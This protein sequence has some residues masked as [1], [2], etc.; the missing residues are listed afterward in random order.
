MTSLAHDTTNDTRLPDFMGTVRELGR[1]SAE[2]KDALPNLAMAFARAVYDGVIDIAKDKD[3][4]DGAARVFAA[5]SQAEGKKA[6]HDRTEKGLKANV[7]KLRQIGAAA[8]NPKFDFVDVLNRAHTIRQEAKADDIDVKPAYA[9][10]VDVA[11]EQLKQDDELTDEQIFSVVTVTESTKDVTLEGK[12]KQVGKLLEG[13]ITGEK[14]KDKDGNPI[15]D[16]S[17]EV[18]AASEQI[19]T[20]LAALLTKAQA[21]QDD[22][23]LAEIL[24][25]RAANAPK[26]IEGTVVETTSDFE[27]AA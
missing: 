21:E 20:R 5:Y 27:I 10:F 13:I 19:N 14:W 1:A 24:E 12:L 4:L 11:R 18:I 9:G 16:Q 6:M 7:S 23:T 26:Q 25:R 3:G 15:M 17:P 2:G 8:S 22:K